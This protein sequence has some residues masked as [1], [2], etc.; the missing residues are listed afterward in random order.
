MD[1][2]IHS[3]VVRFVESKEKK[4]TAPPWHGVIRHVQ[5]NTESRF[6][7]IEEALSFMEGYVELDRPAGKSPQ[8][9]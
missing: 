9:Q 7:R 4:P 1:T 5:T 2:T 3:F 6:A 8:K